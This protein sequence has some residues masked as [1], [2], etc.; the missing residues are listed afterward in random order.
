MQVLEQGELGLGQLDRPVPAPD[1]P[2]PGIE[3]EIGVGELLRRPAV[4]PPQQRPQSGEELLER[5]GLDDIVVGP[6]V[7]AVDAV[8]DGVARRQHQDRSVIAARPQLPGDLQAIALWHQHVEHDRVQRISRSDRTE[9]LLAVR[10]QLDVVA[11]ELQRSFERP[12]EL[13]LVVY[14]QYSHGPCCRD[15]LR[16]A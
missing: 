11:L 14:D 2:G 4:G 6:G 15:R 9:S 8:L 1:L 16:G 12:S 10:R 5:E 7:E 13:R 3:G